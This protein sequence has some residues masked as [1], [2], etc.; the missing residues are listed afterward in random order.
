MLLTIR[1]VPGRV[2]A[3]T[4]PDD[5]QWLEI[6]RV[7]S[8]Q[9]ERSHLSGGYRSSALQTQSDRPFGLWA[10]EPTLALLNLF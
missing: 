5:P 4:L 1:R 7:V 3:R 6:I 8:Q 9:C 10:R 2:W